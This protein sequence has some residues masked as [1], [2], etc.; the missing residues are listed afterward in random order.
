[1]GT[2]E[3]NYPVDPKS[4]EQNTF[5]AFQALKKG[6]LDLK[7]EPV[8]FTYTYDDHKRIAYLHSETIKIKDV[9]RYLQLTLGKEVN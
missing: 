7:S 1:V 5:L 6:A 9:A 2:I 3:F 4:L 8:K